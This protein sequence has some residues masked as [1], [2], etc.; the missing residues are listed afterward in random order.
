M[1]KISLIG[2]RG[3]ELFIPDSA[4]TIISN[5]DAFGA[6][7]NAMGGAASENSNKEE[8]GSTSAATTAFAQNT[9]SIITANNL[10]RERETRREETASFNSAIE[11]STEATIG[12]GGS[13]VIETQV[14]N[15]VEYASIDQV[16]KASAL[17][18]K[19]ARAQVFADMKNRP[20]IRR[21]IGVGR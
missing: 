1:N 21:Q 7:R 9:N 12:G 8:G 4:G 18:I 15:N 17:A 13:M 11:R 10:I 16:Q 19:Q 5:K 2:E 3:P 14:I 20:S 6:A